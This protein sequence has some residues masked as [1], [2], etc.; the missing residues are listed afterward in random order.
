MARLRASRPEIPTRTLAIPIRAFEGRSRVRLSAAVNERR[1]AIRCRLNPVEC[2][3]L[4]QNRTSSSEACFQLDVSPN[5]GHVF[6]GQYH[7]SFD[8]I[9]PEIGMKHEEF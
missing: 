8:E 7:V 6:D 3:I 1:K 5:P 2:H 4:S 9:V